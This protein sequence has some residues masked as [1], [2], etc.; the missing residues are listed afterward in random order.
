MKRTMSPELKRQLISR[1]HKKQYQIVYKMS[2]ANNG[3]NID[4]SI[5]ELDKQYHEIDNEIRK[6]SA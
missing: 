4:E 6:L 1:L 5:L 3:I 2:Q